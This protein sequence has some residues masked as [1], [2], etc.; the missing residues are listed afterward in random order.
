MPWWTAALALPTRSIARAFRR[1]NV[2]VT[3]LCHNVVDHESAGW[4]RSVARW[5]FREASHF[6]VSSEAEAA[7]LE[8]VRHGAT[9]TIHPHPVYRRLA[10]P[11]TIPPRRSSREILFFGLIRPYKGLEVL[12]EALA[13]LPQEEWSLTVAGEPW[14]SLD[15]LKHRTEAAGIA[16]RIEWIERYVSDVEAASLFSRADAVVLPYRRATGC[17]VLAM[18]LGVEKPVIASA[19]SGLREQVVDGKTGWLVTPGD[20]AALAEAIR[21]IRS[22]RAASMKDAIRELSERWTWD[23]LARTLIDD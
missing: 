19:V 11:G 21:Q 3:L 8:E 18:A 9:V 7:R 15:A 12:I 22:D 17:G 5:V 23:S 14:Q 1:A 10:P 13:L 20:P 16:G 6:V 4:K 2:P